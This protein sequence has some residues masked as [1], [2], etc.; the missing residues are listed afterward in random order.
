MDYPQLT[1]GEVLPPL[2]TVAGPLKI[3]S[4]VDISF[5]GPFNKIKLNPLLTSYPAKPPV[6]MSRNEFYVDDR[7]YL[8]S[9]GYDNTGIV[10]RALML[11][12]ATNIYSLHI[13]TRW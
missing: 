4:F 9:L 2:V 1:I 3:P 11:A 5:Q 6:M 7:T 10:H 12:N 13:Y 8:Q